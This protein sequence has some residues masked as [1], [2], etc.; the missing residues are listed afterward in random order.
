[1]QIKS[2]KAIDGPNVHSYRP[3]MV[4]S[5]D[6]EELTNRET[7]ELH[8]F[9]DRLLELL[10]GLSEHVC[11]LGRPGGLLERL[12]DGTYFGHVIEHI[13]LELSNPAGV[14]VS[15]G[16]TR[17][18]DNPAVYT[19]IV[20]YTCAPVMRHL[21]ET[22]VEIV[23]HL[24]WGKP[25]LE[26]ESRLRTARDIREGTSLGPST[27]AIVA[28]A[29]SRGVPVQRLND[30][31][32]VQLGYGARRRIIEAAVGSMTSAIAVE[33]ASDKQL[34]RRLLEE[35]FVPVPAGG[36][37]A[38]EQDALRLFESMDVPVAIKPRNGNQ[39]RGVT[40]GV[41]TREEVR[42]AFKDA[43][44]VSSGPVVVEEMFTGRDYRVLIIGG[45]L[46]AAERA[47]SRRS[48]RGRR[49]HRRATGGRGEPRSQA[50]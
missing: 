2:I 10:P 8:G 22:A 5:L 4:M 20:E 16:R 26:L 28:A 35:A 14:P 48:Y 29:R 23:E 3:V 34:T 39:G 7:R 17:V 15:F 30:D 33:I 37:A 31:S 19:I 13:A 49:E 36:V 42:K 46:V 9:N 18:T 45:R 40:L 41:R 43:A 6:L 11:G 50:W 24:V 38:K 47:A 12:A 25:Y 32:L 27:A 44:S 21:L 1:M